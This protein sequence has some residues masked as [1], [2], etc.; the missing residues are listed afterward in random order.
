MAEGQE[1][2]LVHLG[3]PIRNS[4]L[5]GAVQRANVNVN[6]AFDSWRS[7]YFTPL[8]L[9]DTNIS[10]DLADPDGDGLSN[11]L[12]FG[13]SLNP[14]SATGGSGALPASM[15]QDVGGTN[16]LTLSF[17]RR[18]PAL[19]LS[20]S[21]QTNAGTLAAPDWLSNAV[22]VGSAT[23]NGDGT[24]TVTFRDVQPASGNTRRFMRVQ[25]VRTP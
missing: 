14:R 18:T 11:L 24:E 1:S 16:Y 13:L 21:V 10:G 23:S 3:Q 25:V 8:E 12:E 19:D 20:Y 7:T 17:K 9:S 6:A 15:V 4:T 5:L 22:Q 2:F